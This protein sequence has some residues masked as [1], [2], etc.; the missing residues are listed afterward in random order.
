MSD[1]CFEVL[2]AYHDMHLLLHVE[3]FEILSMQCDGRLQWLFQY[4]CRSISDRR[5]VIGSVIPL[6]SWIFSVKL[7]KTAL[8]S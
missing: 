6:P 3:V 7:V 4:C 2:D 1:D 8:P 5:C